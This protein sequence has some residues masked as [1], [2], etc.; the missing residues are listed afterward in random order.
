[1]RDGCCHGEALDLGK[2]V[3]CAQVSAEFLSYSL[4][5]GNDLVTPRPQFAF[6]GLKPG[7]RWCLCATRWKEALDAGCAPPV[8]LQSTH[9]EALDV[10]SI[11]DLENHA[12]GESADH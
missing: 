10:V 2:H 5:R 4:S 6:P 3:I 12:L 8:V 7:D 11:H 1:M 9:I